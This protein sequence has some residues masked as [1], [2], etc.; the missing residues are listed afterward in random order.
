VARVRWMLTTG[1]E[2]PLSGP[3]AG[4]ETSSRY[5]ARWVFE[6]LYEPISDSVPPR[7]QGHPG[8]ASAE[9]TD[10]RPVFPRRRMTSVLSLSKWEGATRRESSRGRFS[11]CVVSILRIYI[12]PLSRIASKLRIY[13]TDL[14]R[15]CTTS[16]HRHGMDVQLSRTD[17]WRS[18]GNLLPLRHSNELHLTTLL[19][20]ALGKRPREDESGSG[21]T[22]GGDGDGVPEMPPPDM[23]DSSDEE[24]GP[25]PTAPGEEEGS[26]GATNGQKRK[27]KKRAGE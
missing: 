17:P 23:E 10:V 12:I 11:C 1:A 9:G 6:L 7:P 20:T 26:N 8:I 16:P 27:K 14:S 4:C 21:G 15:L 24:I 18:T 22:D 2:T 19:A 5:P 25:M 3:R 13:T